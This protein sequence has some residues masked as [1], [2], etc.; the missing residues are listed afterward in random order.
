MSCNYLVTA[1]KPTA[2]T[3]T[4]KGNFTSPGDLNLIQAKGSYLVV[5]R[6]TPEGLKPVVDVNINGRITIMQLFRPKGEAKDLLFFMTAQYHLAVLS[7]DSSTGDLVTRAYGSVKDR[8]GHPT[9]GRQIGLVDPN[10]KVITL[11]LYSG[12]LKVVPLELDSQQELKAFN[13]RLEDLYVIDVQFLHGC[14]LPTIAYLAEDGQVGRVL[15]TAAVSVRDKELLCGPWK[16]TSVEPQASL[17]HPVP[18]PLGGVVIVGAQTISYHSQAVQ[19]SID[20]PVIKES[21]VSCIGEVDGSRC[22]LGDM[23]GRLLMLFIESEQPMDSEGPT[24]A[25]LRLELLG[26]T[27]APSCLAYLDNGVVFVGS[28]FGDSQLV[29]LSTTATEEGGFVEVIEQVTNIAPVMDMSVVDIDKQGQDVIMSCSGHGRDGS[30]RV[31]RSGIG[32]NEAASIDLPGIKGVWAVHCGVGEDGLDNTLVVTFVGQTTV[33]SLRGEE[34]EET[35]IAGLATDRQ[36]FFCGNIPGKKIVQI[37]SQSVRLINQETLDLICEWRPPSDKNI[38]T[39]SGNQA[40]QLVVAVGRDLYYLEIHGDQVQEINHTSMPHEVACV[41][42]S[43]LVGREK[44]GFLAVGMWTEISVKVLR[45]PSLELLHTQLLGGD[46]LPR[47]VIMVSFSATPYL[48]CALGDGCLLYYHLDINSG[49]LSASK[50]VVLGT[51]PI[52]LKSF[53]LSGS[54]HVFACSNHPTIIHSSNHK[55]LFS[56]VNLKEV[57]YLC[58][59]NSGAF[60][61]SLALVDDSTLTIGFVDQIQM[62]H[63]QTIPL[64]ET[65]RRIA[66]QESTNTFAVLSC[67]IDVPSH[68]PPGSFIPQRASVSTTVPSRT[69]CPAPDDLQVAPDGVDELEVFSVLLV[70]QTNFDVTHAYQLFPREHAVSIASCTVGS[71]P[72]S[73]YFVV[74]TA[75]VLPSE[76]EPVRGRILVFQVTDAKALKLVHQLDKE[77]CVYQVVPFNDKIVAAVNSIVVVYRWSDECTLVEECSYTK[78]VLALYLKANGDF[79]LVG[80]LLRSLKLLVY[81]PETP[82]LEECALDTNL[83]P[84]YLTSIEMIDDENYVGADG[85]HVF[86][87]QKNSEAA[88]EADLAYMLQPSRMYIGDNINVFGRGSLVMEHPGSTPS[89]FQAKPLL[90]GTVH[91]AIGLIGQLLPETYALLS[92]L[93]SKMVHAIRSVG[94]IDYDAYRSFENEHKTKMTEG[95]IDGDLVERFLDLP[96]SEIEEICKGIKVRG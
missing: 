28:V 34:V 29:K 30:L 22:L 47:S 40:E 42:I 55:L 48:L 54:R 2:V 72:K 15:K 8:V 9:E 74:G 44:A 32:I 70:D 91:G 92:K 56:N 49:T 61:D 10:C 50:R 33:L 89:L 96:P 1:Y 53:E 62:L 27:S 83:N 73:A 82:C 25:R 16:K 69:V 78:N 36:T 75:F 31:V 19:H 17:L 65:P 90:Y 52:V 85:R 38:S 60:K 12:L 18:T 11:H 21:I 14:D 84:V 24:V 4:V 67:R 57:N 76:K 66:Y 88:V 46:T 45:V 63:I 5:N 59:L 26:E 58:T 7:Y 79:L 6:V 68:D 35:E 39:A 94:N 93:Q 43:P 77:G 23:N 37:T 51:K 87:C 41:D 20:P 81:K 64:G 3:G 13:I 95:F 80:D 71:D 86:V